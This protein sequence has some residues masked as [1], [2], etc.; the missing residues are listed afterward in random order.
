MINYKSWIYNK[1]STDSGLLAIIGSTNNISD[2]WPE[3]FESFPLVIYQDENQSDW[4]Y[5]DNLPSGSDIRF[6]IDIFTKIDGPTTTEIAIEIARIFRDLFWN[7]GTNGET[8]DQ[9]EGV[10]HRVM[11]FSRALFPTEI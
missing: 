7:C 8:P 10:R 9:N 5:R 2:S 1:L 4:E 3:T 6:K 11:R